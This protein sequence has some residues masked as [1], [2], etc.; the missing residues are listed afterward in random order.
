[1][2][3]VSQEYRSLLTRFTKPT[4][5]LPQGDRYDREDLLRDQFQLT[6]S[7]KYRV[8][9][10]PIGRI[11]GGARVAIVGITGGFTQMDIAFRVARQGLSA[12]FSLLADD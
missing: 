11:N 5:A 12:G 8:F 7:G 10:A 4:L 2:P 1:M 3:D 9:Y 6:E